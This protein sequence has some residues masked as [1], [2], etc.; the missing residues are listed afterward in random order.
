[1]ECS[2][3]YEDQNQSGKLRPRTSNWVMVDPGKGRAFLLGFFWDGGQ[4][5][6]C[7]HRN[8]LSSRWGKMGAKAGVGG[9]RLWNWFHAGVRRSPKEEIIRA[10]FSF[11]FL[12]VCEEECEH[13]MA[14]RE[15]WRGQKRKR[16]ATCIKERGSAWQKAHCCFSA[17]S[18]QHHKK[19]MFCLLF[20]DSFGCSF[21]LWVMFCA[22]FVFFFWGKGGFSW[23]WWSLHIFVLWMSTNGL[24]YEII[25]LKFDQIVK[26]TKKIFQC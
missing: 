13:T 1:M 11:F 15:K 10:C 12:W 20:T 21:I 7:W 22:D 24:F 23:H 5:W 3:L 25:T 18:R 2:Y 26:K 4:W 19:S 9:C 14:G 8:S 17:G 6:C 16:E